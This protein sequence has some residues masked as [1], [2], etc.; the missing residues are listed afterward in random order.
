MA[1][2]TGHD[3]RRNCWSSS[4][5]P[6]VVES[7]P[8]P[9][10]GLRLPW[11]LPSLSFRDDLTGHCAEGGGSEVLMQ[12]AR[13]VSARIRKWLGLLGKRPAKAPYGAG[14]WGR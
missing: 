11:R 9:V 13:S 3:E 8:L 6:L 14:A 10:A 12:V 7:A 4:S 5:V 1:Q 2:D